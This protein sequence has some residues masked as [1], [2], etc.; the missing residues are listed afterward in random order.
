MLTGDK[1][2]TAINIGLSCNLLS[3]EM[4]LM[5]CNGDQEWLSEF[6]VR[7]IQ[8][9]RNHQNPRVAFL[10]FWIFVTFFD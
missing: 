3:S 6:F 8:E 7:N 2:E 1:Q 4:E 10:S 5:I 9:K